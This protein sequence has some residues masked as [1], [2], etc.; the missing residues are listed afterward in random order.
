MDVV[1]RANIG[2]SNSRI[3]GKSEISGVLN[4]VK[5]SMKR[6]SKRLN[7]V[8]TRKPGPGN[9]PAELGFFA[10]IIVVSPLKSLCVVRSYS[11]ESDRLGASSIRPELLVVYYAAALARSCRSVIRCRHLLSRFAARE[12]SWLVSGVTTA[13]KGLRQHHL[14]RSMGHS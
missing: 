6:E 10:V 4:S 5:F 13:R 14:M 11:S 2:K 7:S 9:I 3:S 1:P 8:F 12:V